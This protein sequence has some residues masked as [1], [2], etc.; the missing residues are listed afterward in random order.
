MPQP[1]VPAALS[2]SLRGCATAFQITHDPLF[3]LAA[4]LIHHLVLGTHAHQ[5]CAINNTLY[6]IQA[7]VALL[8][9]T[10]ASTGLLSSQALINHDDED[11][12]GGQTD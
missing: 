4:L 7:S 9:L 2:Q 12:D 11:P 1:H 5:G 6:C 10:S 8:P 3:T